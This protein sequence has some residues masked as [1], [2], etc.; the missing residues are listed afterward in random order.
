M[1]VTAGF[2]AAGIGFFV[3]AAVWMGTCTGSTVD[4]LACGAPQRALLAVGAPAILL[5]GGLYA[6]A[7]SMRARRDHI[8][9][10]VSAAWLLALMVLTAAPNL[11]GYLS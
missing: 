8:A 6:W 10:V 2:T 3:L 7:R 11:P 9:W 4:P 5:I 1:R